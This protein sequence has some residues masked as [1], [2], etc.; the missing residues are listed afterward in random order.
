[1]S[2]FR[3]ARRFLLAALLTGVLFAVAAVPAGALTDPNQWGD[4]FCNETVAWLSG[5]MQGAQQ[6]SEKAADPTLT[7]ADGKQLMVDFLNTGVSSTKS[8]G[9]TMKKAGAPAI[10]NGPKIQAAILAGIAGS[11]AKLAA[12]DTAAKVLPTKPQKAFEAGAKRIGNQLST[13]T[14]PFQKGLSAADKL[15]KGNQLGSVLQ[16]RPACA[17]LV[18][19]SLGS[20]G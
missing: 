5:A 16:A 10:T 2:S 13:F 19:N 3:V 1:M 4:T 14:Q 6:V 7:A 11:G 8:F 12:L 15:D 9:Q 20:G 18:N 17:P